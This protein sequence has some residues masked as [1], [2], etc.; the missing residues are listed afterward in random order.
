[1]QSRALLCW[2]FVRKADRRLGLCVP[3]LLLLKQSVVAD[4]LAWEASE[5]PN[6]PVNFVQSRYKRDRRTH[7]LYA[8]AEFPHFRSYI[9]AYASRY[10]SR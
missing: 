5:R 7:P 2:K 6:Y 9:Y 4:N 10:T 3:V 8:I 1:M